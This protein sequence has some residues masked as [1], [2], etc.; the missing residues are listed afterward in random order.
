MTLLIG[1]AGLQLLFQV[2]LVITVILRQQQQKQL[3]VTKVPVDVTFRKE[4][5][6]L[7][8][9][10]KVKPIDLKNNEFKE[11]IW[12]EVRK[13]S[14]GDDYLSFITGSSINFAKAKSFNETIWPALEANCSILLV[15]QNNLP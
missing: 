15:R 11:S 7:F 3:Q 12:K 1:A 14:Q 5:G 8:I 2:L 9:N 13:F 6:N 10:F 4:E